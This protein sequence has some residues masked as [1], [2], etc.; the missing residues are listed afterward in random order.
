M[1]QEIKS[2]TVLLATDDKAIIHETE[3]FPEVEFVYL[4]RERRTGIGGK[5]G[6][7]NGMWK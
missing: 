1:L 2:H 5:G 6:V 3:L 4:P 7:Q